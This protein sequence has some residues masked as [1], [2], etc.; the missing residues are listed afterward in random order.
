MQGRDSIALKQKVDV[1]EMI[2]NMKQIEFGVECCS[3]LDLCH[4]LT[5]DPDGYYR[6]LQSVHFSE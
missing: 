2:S 1:V 5:K 3:K 6:T 4:M